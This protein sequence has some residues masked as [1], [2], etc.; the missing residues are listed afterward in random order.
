LPI[1]YLN[2]KYGG[3]PCIFFLLC[4]VLASELPAYQITTSSNAKN[5]PFVEVNVIK[6][7]AYSL[8]T[9]GS[10]DAFISQLK[11]KVGTKLYLMHNLRSAIL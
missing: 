7:L 1:T 5:S 10:I 6:D 11:E 4:Y 9:G 8:V 3:N 2:L